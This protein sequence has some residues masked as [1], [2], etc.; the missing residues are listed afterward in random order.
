MRV[1]VC[2]QERV[3]PAA[4]RALARLLFASESPPDPIL[5]SAA[6]RRAPGRAG[7]ELAGPRISHT[8]S[9]KRRA[10]GR[11]PAERPPQPGEASD[12]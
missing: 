5:N 6:E 7:G 3:D 2:L 4:A 8:Q 1:V 10:G 12:G 9:R 11:R